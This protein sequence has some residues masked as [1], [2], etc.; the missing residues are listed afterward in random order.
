MRWIANG[1]VAFSKENAGA[2][3]IDGEPDV[4][5][6]TTGAE[7][8]GEMAIQI[9]AGAVFAA[10]FLAVRDLIHPKS[11]LRLAMDRGVQSLIDRELPRTLL[12]PEAVDEA[13]RT[14][15]EETARD[16]RDRYGD[17]ILSAPFDPPRDLVEELAERAISKGSYASAADA[18]EYLGTRNQRV[19]DLVASGLRTLKSTTVPDSSG[20]AT[21]TTLSSTL[22]SAA[23]TFILALR[24]KNPLEP[25]FQKQAI[26]FHFKHLERREKFYKALVTGRDDEA[27]GI[28]ID[29]LLADREVS[30]SVRGSLTRSPTRKAFVRE[31]AISLSGGRE[32][33]EEFLT[34]YRASVE[35]LRSGGDTP[36]PAPVQSALAAQEGNADD[37]IGLL[38]NLAVSHPVSTLVCRTILVP[39]KGL[40]LIPI[41]FEGNS[42]VGVLGLSVNNPG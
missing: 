34:R 38:K 1:S 25:L 18:L 39:Q 36:D 4:S 15:Y 31:L 35:V 9:L 37:G 21:E 2:F 7:A 8:A 17:R 41:V 23:R 12:D 40:F 42:A 10:D 14:A 5:M 28:C 30:E 11:K 32:P 6:R 20:D 29:Y 26:D 16:I 13:E 19:G 3:E 27:V 24:L 33:Y 22:N